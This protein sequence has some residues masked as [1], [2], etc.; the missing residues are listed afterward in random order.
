MSERVVNQQLATNLEN[1]YF[2]YSENAGNEAQV[3]HLFKDETYL[4][5]SYQ[6][7]S[8]LQQE[9]FKSYGG[10]SL[11]KDGRKTGT[12]KKTGSELLLKTEDNSTVTYTQN[13]YGISTVAANNK[14]A[15]WKEVDRSDELYYELILGYGECVNRLKYTE[16]ELG[17]RITVNENGWGQGEVWLNFDKSKLIPV[18]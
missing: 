18:V 15:N 2:N 13:T 8:S 9:W 14:R 17:N 16:N 4:E 11:K 5:V 1:L 12:F 7:D 6:L 10:W 3:L